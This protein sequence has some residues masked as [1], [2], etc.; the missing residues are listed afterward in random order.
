MKVEARQQALSMRID[1]GASVGE[2][3]ASLKISKST[4]SRWVRDVCLT[5]VQLQKL[6]AR[7]P[8]HNNQLRGSNRLKESSKVLRQQYQEEGR[9]R[10]QLGD[11]LHLAGCMLYWAEGSKSRNVITFTNSDPDMVVFSRVSFG[12]VMKWSRA[13]LRFTSMAS[14]TAILLKKLNSSG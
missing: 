11:P 2:I 5:E 1:N 3:A 13:K 14:T 7:N 4:V 12:A 6:S 8:I 10:A 9:K